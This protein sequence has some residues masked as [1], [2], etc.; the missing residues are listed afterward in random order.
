MRPPRVLWC[1]LENNSV[2]RFASPSVVVGVHQFARPPYVR[3]VGGE[4]P[5]SKNSPTLIMTSK[6][7]PKLLSLDTRTYNTISEHIL[8]RK[9]DEFDKNGDGTLDKEE[10]CAA[11][12]AVGSRASLKDLDSNGDDR[13]TF[14]EFQVCA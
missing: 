2:R 6:A 10:L 14:E 9:F 8:R 11:L 4:L 5:S 7:P 3:A 13:V 1:W 12:T